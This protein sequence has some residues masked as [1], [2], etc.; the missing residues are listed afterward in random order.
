MTAASIYR[1]TLALILVGPTWA[2]DTDGE[3][4][5]ALYA[6]GIFA[7]LEGDTKTA[8]KHFEATLAS[9]ASS[10]TLARKASNF[11]LADD[12]LPSAAKT[13]RT[14]ADSQPGHLQSHLYY[15]DFLEQYASRDAIAQQA[16]TEL[17]IGANERFPNE[18][19]VYTR[20]INLHENLG[21][22]EKSR[23]VFNA[24]FE[25]EGA[26]PQHWMSL[27][28]IA[29]TLLPGDSPEL[30]EKL[31]LIAAKTVETG[32]GIPMAARSASDY[33]R[34][35]G[36]MEEAIAVL[37]KH[38][39]I[40]PDSLALR[41]R[42]GLL[43]LYAKQV[44]E[45]LKTLQETLQIDPDQILAHRS[46]AHYHA[47]NDQAEKALYHSAEVL[48]IAGGAPEDFL[49]LADQYLELKK[50][51]EARL[52]L[53]KARFDHPES[54]ALAARLAIATLRDGDTTTA[55][56]LFRQAEALAKESDDPTDKEYLDADFQLE[57]AGSLRAAGDIAA[58]ES[59]LRD[60]IRGI[61]PE[62]PKK[63]AR[64]LRELARLWIEQD[65]N[66]APAASLLKRAE[67]LEPGNAE[68]K[69]LLE[70]AKGK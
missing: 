3:K 10:F 2:G 63:A 19:G 23:A 18:Y 60:A 7:E 25:V 69:E 52:L 56:R 61:P 22:N 11:Q 59:R 1:F 66:L 70:K 26:G 45:G 48:R 12:D 65:K 47:R 41:T 20:L 39:E 54:P 51:H 55:A 30:K 67:S 4:N 43:Q 38:L 16:V 31:D 15:A 53:E 29:R 21:E 58:A 13:L 68:T 36:R 6:K 42:L 44:D 34:K 9:D 5:L 35:T 37:Q 40:Q 49:E 8:R 17:L 32:V 64:A 28:P 14:Y 50:P 57:F 33:Y 27:G 46:L 24:Q 62:Q